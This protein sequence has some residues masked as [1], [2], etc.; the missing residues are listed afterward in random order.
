MVDESEVLIPIVTHDDYF[1][2]LSSF[3]RREGH[4]NQRD[5]FSGRVSHTLLALTSSGTSF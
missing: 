1:A 2:E 5:T 4:V 3:R